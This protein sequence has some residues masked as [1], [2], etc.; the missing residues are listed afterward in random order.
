MKKGLTNGKKSD[1]ITK[2]SAQRDREGTERVE[3]KMQKKLEKSFEKVL[4]KG[5]RL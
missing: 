1:R 2:L 5:I 4:D 3:E